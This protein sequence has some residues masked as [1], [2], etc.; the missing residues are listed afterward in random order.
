MTARP[1]QL[2]VEVDL[3]ADADAVE[4]DEA[5]RRLRQELLELDVEDV[6]RPA[7]AA[8]PEGARGVETAILGTLLITASGEV[9]AAVVRRVE[10]W[11]TRR[12]SRSVKLAIEGDS[13]ELTDL[14][15]GD[16]KRLLEA[17]LA[18]HGASPQ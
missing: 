11:L 14:S 9:I 12:S 7:S 2:Q 10:S 3:E 6:E 18:R 8:P 17:F 4:L 15:S 16:Q 5:T 1:V 13:I